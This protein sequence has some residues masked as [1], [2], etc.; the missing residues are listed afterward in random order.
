MFAAHQHS[1]ED[2]HAEFLARASRGD[3]ATLGA[4]YEEYA[5]LV[6]ATALV[7]C[8]SHADAEDIVQDIFLGLPTAL[9]RYEHRRERGFES[10][11]RRM[12]ANLALS[13]MRRRQRRALRLATFEA[14]PACTEDRDID[15]RIDLTRAL[16]RPRK[17]DRL[18]VLLHDVAGFTHEEIG[19]ALGIT[20]TASRSRLARAR[21]KLRRILRG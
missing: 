5:G 11:L 3:A 14:H 21:R 2:N 20:R 16:T 9:M 7:F 18:L 4:L 8:E 10:W 15:A 12:T 13:R 6:Y 19:E 17:R 1:A